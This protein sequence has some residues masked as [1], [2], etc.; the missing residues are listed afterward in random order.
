[1]ETLLIHD[2]QTEYTIVIPDDA[3]PVEQTA[4]EE[5]Q[6]YLQKALGAVLPIQQ[7]NRTFAKA[8]YIGHT[9]YARSAGILGTSTENWIIRVQDG[10]VILTGGVNANDRGIIYAV[11]HFL[12][13]IVGIRWWSVW[14]EYI[15]KLTRLSLASDFRKEGTPA[16]PYRK[17]LHHRKLDGFYYDARNRGNVVGDDGLPDGAYHPSIRKLGGAMQMGRPHHV[18]WTNIS[19]LQNIFRF[20]PNGLP[21]VPQTANGSHMGCIV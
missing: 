9:E 18:H 15:P 20:T 13:D 6:Q 7:E 16:F 21:S 5:L 4:A 14:E 19:C 17:I 3:Q 11:Y 8:F 12:E 2:Q 1:M 10:N